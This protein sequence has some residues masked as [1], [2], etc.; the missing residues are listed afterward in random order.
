[1]RRLLISALILGATLNT[2]SFAVAGC[3]SDCQDEY[4][5]SVDSCKSSYGSDPDDSDSLRSC[6]DDAKSDFDSCEDDCDS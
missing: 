2:A 6:V 1:M 4:E 3:K 5:S